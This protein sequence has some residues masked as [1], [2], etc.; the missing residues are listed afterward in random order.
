MRTP[1]L[2]RFASV[3]GL[4][5]LTLGTLAVA[6]PVEAGAATSATA[7][8]LNPAAAKKAGFP[9]VYAAAKV[10]K[11]P[12]PKNCSSSVEAAYENA[13]HKSGLVSQTLVCKTPAAAKAAFAGFKAQAPA[14]KTIPVPKALGS[15]SFATAA[16]AP[17]YTLLWLHGTKVGFTGIDTDITASSNEAGKVPVTPLTA[18]QAKV[19]GAAAVTQN[20]L[21]NK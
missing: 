14:T 12:G 1:R 6:L 4:T 7:Y 3:T 13:G 8:V 5:A 16:G 2:R 18:A 17:E 20:A 15:V 10:T 19:L 21:L 9:V 11:N